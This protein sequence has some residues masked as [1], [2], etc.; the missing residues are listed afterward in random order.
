[1]KI[2]LKHLQS[3]KA[4]RYYMTH[5]ELITVSCYK[6][7]FGDNRLAG[8][9][10]KAAA[11]VRVLL[12]VLM[13]LGAML[14]PVIGSA[15]PLSVEGWQKAIKDTQQFKAGCFQASYPSMKWKEIP[16]A[17][18]ESQSYVRPAP[19]GEMIQT[20]QVV[21]AGYVAS[22]AENDP[23][24]SAAEG[25]FINVK[26]VTG[27]IDTLAGSN[28][29]SL[30]INSN[31][32]DL[33]ADSNFCQTGGDGCQGWVQFTNQS[34]KISVWHIILGANA[35][36]CQGKG[37]I[38]GNVCYI[39]SGLTGVP[40]QPISNINNKMIFS[41]KTAGG[42][43]VVTLFIGGEAYSASAQTPLEFKNFPQVWREAQFNIVGRGG[44]SRLYFNDTAQLTIR[45]K[46]DNG[47]TKPPICLN[48]NTTAEGNN[49][50]YNSPCC[51]YGG[52]E[53]SIAFVE[54][55][56]P[57]ITVSSCA[58]L[59]NNTITPNVPSGGGTI[60]PSGPLNVPNEA[61]SVFTVTPS[62]GYRIASVSGCGGS[63]SGNSF[64]TA[65]A[66]GN[67]TVTADFTASPVNFTLTAN[68]SAGG[69]IT[70]SGTVL[71]P[72]GTTKTFIVTPNMGYR[73]SSVDG[74]CGG[75]LS[76]ST[77][78]TKAIN[79][80]CTVT[81]AF[82]LLT[83][84]VKTSAGS[85]YGIFSSS[86]GDT[87]S[88]LGPVTV[89]WGKTQSFT[90]MPA[91]GFKL[92]AFYALPVFGCNGTLSG[93]TYTTGPITDDC[94]IT[95]LL[96]PISPTSYTVTF[97]T[98]GAGGVIHSNSGQGEI[99]AASGMTPRFFL[100]SIMGYTLASVD[101]SCPKGILEA[102][103]TNNWRYTTS[104]ITADC[105][106]IATFAQVI[107]SKTYTVTSKPGVGGMIS[108]LG[109]VA[110][111][112]GAV[113]T[114]TITP[115]TG[116]KISTVYSNCGGSLSG[117]TYT[118]GAI[119][120]NCYVDVPFEPITPIYLITASVSGTGGA[121]SPSTY[122][123][124]PIGKT[125]V[126]TLIPNMNYLVSSVGGTCGGTLSGNT[127]TTKAIT[128]HCTVT[129]T[130]TPRPTTYT[131]TANAGTGGTISPPGSVV[132]NSGAS[133]TFTVTPNAGYKTAS[134]TGCG[135]S[136]VNG[137]MSYT[138]GSITAAC[139]VT[140]LF[141]PVAYTIGGA[142]SGL[143]GSVTLGLSGTN[144][145]AWQTQ[146]FAANDRYTF[147][148]PL[149]PGSN[150]AVRVTA[151][152]AGQTC[153]VTGGTGSNLSAN[154]ANVNLSCTPPVYS[155]STYAYSGGGISPAGSFQVKSGSAYT[156]TVTPNSG[157]YIAWVYGCNGTTLYGSNTNTTARIYTTGAIFG[158]CTV[159]ASFGARI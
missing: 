146:T 2:I 72:S 111:S 21:G 36:W 28:A 12:L 69:T 47:T 82:K 71:V 120:A 158:N 38:E 77:Y 95:A 141:T 34:G 67:C 88:P 68:A 150:W 137:S 37:L 123:S 147:T 142:I 25:S 26:N 40:D 96:D 132:V 18:P 100:F 97:K 143:S 114:Y 153:T 155:I 91:P 16:C 33:P 117:N 128:T 52:A 81:A 94:S 79:G 4:V 73:I 29:Y 110:V 151:Q 3:S 125:Q 136:W 122:I 60:S 17:L 83:Y 11:R 22:V 152:P 115:Y 149:P 10:T 66:T 51:V 41:G 98:S 31:F 157:Y 80:D 134:V 154:V 87:F 7:K 53:P 89:T 76:G 1:M 32:F 93:N 61:I 58:V 124:V 56:G 86:V 45:T 9:K 57:D 159:Y 44:R 135:G 133:Q 23:P 74:S 43:D 90:V 64:T 6:L 105:T 24:I 106:V 140:A 46:I 85:T 39:E 129:A 127:F 119:T 113:K 27:I 54:G 55:T 148:T 75:T 62:S 139:T 59:G 5:E 130:F 30:Q 78:T 20:G 144:P 116:Y 108:P 138:T 13:G 156:F 101:G 48:H 118:T 104:P 65:P 15:Q 102:L 112:A 131:I 70:P 35:N 19:A 84:T 8:W 42:I 107:A 121:I 14:L 103:G 126:F 49:L 50:N 99:K 145:T 92:S 109:N 63:M